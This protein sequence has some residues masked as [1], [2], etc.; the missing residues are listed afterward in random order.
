MS[1]QSRAKPRSIICQQNSTPEKQKTDE[2]LSA[3]PQKIDG[4]QT[5][6][7]RHRGKKEK[8]FKDT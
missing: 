3:T 2:L 6:A 8:N 1:G 7:E 4:N 5:V